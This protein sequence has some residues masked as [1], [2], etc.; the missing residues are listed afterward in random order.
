MKKRSKNAQRGYHLAATA[1]SLL[2]TSAQ[3]LLSIVL[4][5]TN[6][7]CFVMAAKGYVHT[8][9]LPFFRGWREFW[10]GIE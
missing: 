9:W 2:E 5:P 1:I 6:A 7:S 4:A 8:A 10:S 3:T